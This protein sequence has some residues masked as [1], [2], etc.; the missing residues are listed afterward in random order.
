VTALEL[1]FEIQA[2]PSSSPDATEFY[3]GAFM[4]ALI[5]MAGYKTVAE[6]GTHMGAT[7]LHMA[8][9]VGDGGLVITVDREDRCSSR[10]E[11]YNHASRIAFLKQDTLVPIGKMVELLF[12]DDDHSQPHVENE[13]LV[14]SDW[15]VPGGLMLFHDSA[16]PQVRNAINSLHGFR[17]AFLP[18]AS[19]PEC[20]IAI[21]QKC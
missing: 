4:A 14:Q 3:T 15:V 5:S 10:F 9:A 8:E 20:G 19:R 6:L 12:V 7:T 2:D 18:T 16:R 1:I 21:A 11:R 13:I 17:V